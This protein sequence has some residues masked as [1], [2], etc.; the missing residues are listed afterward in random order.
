MSSNH[1]SVERLTAAAYRILA[2]VGWRDDGGWRVVDVDLTADAE[3]R[4]VLERW[5]FGL[6]V[7]YALAGSLLVS[8]Y[9]YSLGGDGTAYISVARKVAAG[10]WWGAV[11]GH[12]SPLLPFTLALLF[13]AGL[14]ETIAFKFHC[15]A[16]GLLALACAYRL[17]FR[18][19]ISE[20]ARRWT[21]TTLAVMVLYYALVHA[22]PDLL[23][24]AVLAAYFSIVFNPRFGDRWWDGP[25]CGVLV[26]LGY[27]AKAY[28]LPFCVLHL[29][30]MTV[31]HFVGRSSTT[32][33][34]RLVGQC[35][36]GLL[37]VALLSGPWIAVVSAKYGGLTISTAGRNAWSFRHPEM[38]QEL[39]PG[40]GF[41]PPAHAGDLSAWDDPASLPE[42]KW[43]PFESAAHVRYTL[44]FVAWNVVRTAWYVVCGSVLTL[45]IMA[46][47]G[48]VGMVGLA[49]RRF[50]PHWLSLLMTI[51]VMASGYVPL[52][53]T[54]RYFW[55][56][57]VLAL[58]MGAQLL[59]GMFA[60]STRTWRTT[61]LALFCATFVVYPLQRL[62]WN[63]NLGREL[64][65]LARTLAQ[66]YH[67][68]GRV[69]SHNRYRESLYLAYHLGASYYNTPRPDWTEAV[70]EQRLAELGVDYYLV[71]EDEAPTRAA[72]A[73][74]VGAEV[75]APAFVD[76]YTEVT[77]GSLSGL[78][79]YAVREP[80]R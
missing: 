26:A 5:V 74:E 58:F 49:R 63:W 12:W 29:L 35:V 42:L 15:L 80:V 2:F 52:D 30:L 32:D 23:A 20:T 31:I 1:S 66:R 68:G 4:P 7:V 33:R 6:L 25:A 36:M 70:T 3:G 53:V 44:G 27:F 75:S 19:R 51:A 37:V 65:S 55:I 56:V 64:P 8:H 34:R 41:W 61:V 57:N 40:L 16:T 77:G 10:D 47:A 38:R 43:S 13:E 59:A 76:K 39:V 45:P 17:S 60:D 54:E 21:V 9:Q 73:R 11:N 50:E 78:K 18:F 72:R 14:S 28:L 22:S 24:V 71:W 67:V 48:L 69:A 62:A 79:V 46:V